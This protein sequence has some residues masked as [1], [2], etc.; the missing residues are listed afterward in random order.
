M[1]I[2]DERNILDL[3]Q[4][5]KQRLDDL[6][7]PVDKKRL[8]QAVLLAAGVATTAATSAAAQTALSST[9]LKS[10]ASAGAAQTTA[11]ATAITTK[12][13]KTAGLFGQ[14]AKASILTKTLTGAIIVG[15]TTTAVVISQQSA[16]APQPVVEVDVKKPAQKE[17]TPEI[18]EPEENSLTELVSL[19][20]EDSEATKRQPSRIKPSSTN[21]KKESNNLEHRSR[22]QQEVEAHQNAK[23]WLEQGNHQR[24]QR[25]YEE[26]LDTFD[27][28]QLVD[29]ARLGLIRAMLGQTTQP[30]SSTASRINKLIASINND[31]IKKRAERL[32]SS[33]RQ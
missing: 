21:A 23:R 3:T 16:K 18:P 6:V 14:I 32:W 20:T 8:Q 10:A 27:N 33:Y 17:Q 11:Q 15:G 1:T 4:M 13:V 5:S 12:A 31:S 19:P 7:E 28:G 24:A 22:F 30:S 26:L 25:A 29:E 2:E 9:S